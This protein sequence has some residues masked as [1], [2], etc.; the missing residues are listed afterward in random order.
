[1][2]T[3][4]KVKVNMPMSFQDGETSSLWEKDTI[5]YYEDKNIIFLKLALL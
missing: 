3:I 5:I 1:M 2:G 4:F